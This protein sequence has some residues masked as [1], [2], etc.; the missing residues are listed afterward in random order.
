MKKSYYEVTYLDDEDTKHL[1]I[2][3]E[4]K[5]I[6]FIKSRFDLIECK[7]VENANFLL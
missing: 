5:D 7:E 1:M 6:K 3:N 2:L 4:E